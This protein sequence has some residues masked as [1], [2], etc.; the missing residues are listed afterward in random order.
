VLPPY[1]PR[2][3]EDDLY[4]LTAPFLASDLALEVQN[5]YTERADVGIHP[6]HATQAVF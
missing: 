3:D 6:G 4:A 1:D 5:I 2:V